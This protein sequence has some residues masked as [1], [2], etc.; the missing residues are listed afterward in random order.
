MSQIK[1][2]HVVG[3]VLLVATLNIANVQ[4]QTPP[5]VEHHESDTPGAT[6]ISWN[7]D[8][9]KE[10]PVGW[11]AEATNQQGP[12]ATWRVIK[13]RTA[14]S[15]ENALAMVSPN[16]D[17][18]GT[19]NI[20]WTKDIRFFDGAIEAYFKAVEGREDQ[21]GG[22]IWR[23]QDKE[24]YYIARFNPLEDNFRIYTVRD[25]ARKTLASVRIALTA[26]EWHSLKIVQQGN[27]YKGYLNGKKILDGRDGLFTSPGGVGLW[28]KADAVTSFDDFSVRHFKHNENKGEIK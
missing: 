6:N 3:A 25:G 5:K 24:N 19:F 16:H 21:G 9:S 18:G 23:V 13:D 12:L 14:P 22:V 17:S 8:G 15:A 26:G 7:F 11:K 1:L 27:H 20:C 10:L 28:T 2:S 4:A